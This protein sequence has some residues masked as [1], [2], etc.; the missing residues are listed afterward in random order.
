MQ[1]QGEPCPASTRAPIGRLQDEE[2]LALLFVT[3]NLGLVRTAAD[4]RPGDQFTRDLIA[5]TLDRPRLPVA[6]RPQQDASG[7]S[8]GSAHFEW[9]YLT[10]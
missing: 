3:H 8:F 5:A 1:Q 6:G 4:H 7:R 10:G 9:L 2:G